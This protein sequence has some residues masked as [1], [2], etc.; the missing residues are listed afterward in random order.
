[1]RKV[2]PEHFPLYLPRRQLRLLCLLVR[3]KPGRSRALPIQARHRVVP[4][5]VP[6]GRYPHSAHTG[7]VMIDMRQFPAEPGLYL[8]ETYAHAPHPSVL[9]RCGAAAS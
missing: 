6:S 5:A 2:A 1:M 7:S 3:G 9:A 4:F 8:R